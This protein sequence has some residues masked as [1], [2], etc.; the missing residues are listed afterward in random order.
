MRITMST[1]KGS[2]H[3]R[4]QDYCWDS[5]PEKS[6]KCCQIIAYEFRAPFW[7]NFVPL[8]V[9]KTVH[10]AADRDLI[11]FRDTDLAVRSPHR[12]FWNM[13]NV[14][15]CGEA[16]LETG[17]KKPFVFLVPS[18]REKTDC[19]NGTKRS[20]RL[21]KPVRQ[22][23]AL[24]QPP[25]RYS[26]T[27]ASSHAVS[28]SFPFKTCVLWSD[29]STDFRFDFRRFR[30]YHQNHFRSCERHIY[31]VWLIRFFLVQLLALL[32]QKWSTARHPF[33]L[34]LPRQQS[35]DFQLWRG[36]IGSRERAWRSRWSEID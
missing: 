1:K 8:P 32:C 22:S 28:H 15:T 35:F 19:Q 25:W 18:S 33:S 36:G 4:E 9:P 21:P 2:L 6:G 20:R 7:S 11:L 29:F 31:V 27:T 12:L 24:W 5:D 30:P 23:L 16:K 26:S 34:L 17:F 10:L 13:W 3:K 14:Q